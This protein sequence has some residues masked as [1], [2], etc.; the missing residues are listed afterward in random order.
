[1][2]QVLKLNAGWMPIE[3]VDW[4]E[5][6]DLWIKAKAEIVSVYDRVIHAGWR[7]KDLP[8]GLQDR[9]AGGMV[10]LDKRI[11]QIYVDRLES[12]KTAMNMPAVIRCLEFVKPPKD[13]PI[14][15]PFTRRNVW[16][17]DR[18]QCQYCG[19]KIS[20]R[21]MTYDHI[22][23]QSVGGP[24]NWKNIV[25]CCQKCNSIK[26]NRTPVE[27]GMS[28]IRRPYAPIVAENYTQNISRKLK[29]MTSHLISIK[30]WRD[31]IYWQVPLYEDECDDA[32][33]SLYAEEIRKHKMEGI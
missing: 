28:L 7:F 4:T 5:A 18:A 23:P 27:A 13:F 19:K 25:C 2:E 16:V 26:R 15:E 1:M 33:N 14:F 3:I 20:L 10:P 17:R 21:Q 8:A 11:Q 12:W 31:F 29:T 32:D 30:E 22:I 9:Y 24:T 6:V